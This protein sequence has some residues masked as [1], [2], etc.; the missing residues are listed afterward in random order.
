MISE[1]IDQNAVD[2]LFLVFACATA[3]LVFWMFEAIWNN[4]KSWILPAVIFPLCI[5]VFIFFYWEQ[6]R[7][8]CFF[9]T[10]FAIITILVSGFVGYGFAEHMYLFLKLMMLWPYFLFEYLMHSYGSF[11]H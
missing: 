7:A 9:A 10:L 8:R 2:N 1:L 6:T 4:D 11:M 3:F 5:V